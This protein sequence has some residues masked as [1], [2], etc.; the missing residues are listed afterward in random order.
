MRSGSALI[1]LIALVTYGCS[2]FGEAAHDRLG[3]QFAGRKPS[4]QLRCET[5]SPAPGPA[6]AVVSPARLMVRGGSDPGQPA[7]VGEL[8]TWGSS[9]WHPAAPIVL[10][11]SANDV[12]VGDVKRILVRNGFTLTEDAQAASAV[13]D[14]AIA[15]LNVKGVPGQL[16]D[17]KGTIRARAAFHAALTRDATVVWK[18]YFEGDDEMRVAYSLTSHSE[19]TLGRAYCRALDWFEEAVRAPTLRGAIAP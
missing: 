7:V 2:A 18:D 15:G 3:W 6:A 5:P 12:L 13:L 9:P 14:T 1:T 19:R 11:G 8:F 4:L 10:E 16:T 17:M